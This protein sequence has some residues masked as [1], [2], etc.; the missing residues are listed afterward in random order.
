MKF[1]KSLK[2]GLFR[3]TNLL[4]G[5]TTGYPLQTLT[6]LFYGGVTASGQVVTTEKA[7]QLDAVFAC[8]RLLSETVAGLP[9]KL[10]ESDGDN[11]AK[12]ARDHPLYNILTY[13][14]NADM[15]GITF[16]GA[17]IASLLLWGNAY[18]FI[19]R[20]V[21]G[22]IVSLYPMLPSQVTVRR[23]QNGSFIY[24]YNY[25][26]NVL[27][28]AEE[29]VFHVRGFSLDGLSGLSPITM[30]RQS[31]GAAMAADETAH[32]QFQNGLLTSTYI[33][34]PTY[35]TE[36]QR[37][38]AKII[39]QRYSSAVN[40]GRSPL[41]EGGWSVENIG[42]KPEDSQLLETRS[43]SV[44]TI[45][46][47]F[48]VPPPLIGHM[49]KST[50]WGTGLEQMNRWF[51]QYGLQAWLTRIEQS[52][53]RC[54]L[55]PT[56]HLKYYAEYNVDALLRGDTT[57]RAQF[58]NAGRQNGWLTANEIR[59]KENLPPLPGGDVLTMQAQMIPATQ[60]GNNQDKIEGDH[61]TN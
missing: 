40:A 58:Y 50:A 3:A 48:G 60:A 18:A 24:S 44:E 61:A 34:A 1:I 19:T 49:T 46:R 15:T 26:G 53:S 25:M 55:S 29:D 30:A 7:L 41:L 23:D 57:A 6:P 28:F 33:K 39:L 17:Y 38:D 14:P 27:T 10:Y 20:N 52:I 4:A 54:L 12:I 32:R 56:D 2:T 8:V 51:L 13:R 16:W 9:L 35:L 31:L 59:A 37:E 36:Q 43:F 21:T 45:C 47:W 5:V 42:L 22:N 11:T